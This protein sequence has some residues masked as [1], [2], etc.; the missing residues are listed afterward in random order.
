METSFTELRN[1][2][3]INVLS[4]RLLGNIN[5]VIIDMSR[6]CVIGFIVPNCKSIWNF[7]RPNQEIFI[8]FCNICKI[9]EDVIL[10]EVVETPRKKSKCRPVRVFD[11]GE[12]FETDA[13]QNQTVKKFDTSGAKISG[14]YGADDRQSTK[15]QNYSN[16]QYLKK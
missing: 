6:N 2:E 9:G 3:V 16:S 4:G 14:K 15:N 10:V 7:F 5:D 8:P 11:A 12:N 13:P 1:K